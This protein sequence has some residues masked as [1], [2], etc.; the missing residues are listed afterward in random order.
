MML[1]DTKVI[2]TYYFI[3]FNSIR[4]FTNEI[5]VMMA[6]ETVEC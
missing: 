3:P 5:L 1:W 6:D 2:P 4:F